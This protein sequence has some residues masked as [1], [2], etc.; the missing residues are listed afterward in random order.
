MKYLGKILAGSFL[1]LSLNSLAQTHLI[2]IEKV[3]KQIDSVQLK[4]FLLNPAEFKSSEKYPVIVFFFGGGWVKGNT[5]QFETFVQHYASKGMISV[6]VDYRVQSRQGTTP[7]EALKDAK[8]AIR[9]LRRNAGELG[10]DPHKIVC[11]GGSAG[12]HLAA[13]CYTNETIDEEKEDLNISSKPNALVLFNPVIDNSKEGY[14]YDRIG[15]NYLEFS[16]LH[17]IRKGFPPTAFFLG[18][19]DKLVPVNTAQLFKKKIE[20]VGSR[21]DLFL[22]KDQQHGFFNLKIFHD[23]ILSKVDAFLQ[24]I[25]YIR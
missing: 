2:S 22:Y 5:T 24:S 21:C 1:I 14:G 4:L 19:K 9:Y 10:I 8:S 13:A 17:N 15:E 16:P 25:G 18:T 6:L 20:T 11:S 3:Y 12:G 7:F 23:D